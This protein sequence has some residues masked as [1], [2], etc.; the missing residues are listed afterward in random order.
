[1]VKK[2]CRINICNNH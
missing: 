2:Q 1:M